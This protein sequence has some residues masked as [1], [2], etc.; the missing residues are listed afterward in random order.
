MRISYDYQFE[1]AL[2]DYHLGR[3]D[4]KL[5][6]ISNKTPDEEGPVAYFFRDIKDLPQLEIQDLDLCSGSILDI[7]AGSGC[8][9]KLLQERNQ[10]N[11]RG[12][13]NRRERSARKTP[14]TRRHPGH[15]P[16]PRAPAAPPGMQIAA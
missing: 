7:G 13:R 11:L 9:S 1:Q 16:T 2:C 15:R 3:K 12:C 5:K 6:V 4:V 8:H 10:L 14:P